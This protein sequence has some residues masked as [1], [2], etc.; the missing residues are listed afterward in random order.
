[1][2][3]H[4]DGRRS[5]YWKGEFIFGQMQNWAVTVMTWM[6]S[7]SQEGAKRGSIHSVKQQEG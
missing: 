6:E 7:V 2:K 4:L 1:M 5:G 3:L